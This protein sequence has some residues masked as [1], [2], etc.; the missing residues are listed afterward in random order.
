MTAT[1]IRMALFAML[2]LCM[3]AQAQFDDTFEVEEWTLDS[4]E[5]EVPKPQHKEYKNALYL[6][7]SPSRYKVDEGDR[8]KFN[9]MV[10][11]YSRFIQVVEDVPYFVEVGANMKFSWQTSD[12]KAR[13][14]TFRVPVNVTYKW[15]PWRKKDFA[16]AP[17]AGASV[18]AI[19]MAREHTGAKSTSL[20][21][22]GGWDSFQV[23][24]QVG[25]R[26][27]LDRYFL[28]F[29]YSRDFRDSSKY[30]GIRECGVHFG[31]GF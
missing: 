16:I 19:A 25:L 7:Y 28:G 30:P 21:G 5:E 11:G 13:V 10:V 4:L 17:Y 14:I 15:Y 24:W 1:R 12:L 2:C 3:N 6:Q 18:R 8:I 31:V 26:L 29:S 27:H 20:L 23:A 22:D 9:E